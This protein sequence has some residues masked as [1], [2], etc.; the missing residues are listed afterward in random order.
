MSIAINTNDQ[1]LQTN[2]VVAKKR[3]LYISYIKGV[4]IIG[5]TLIH[6]I[7]WSNI[8]LTNTGRIIENLLL[9]CVFLF[10]LTT[11]SVLFIAYGQRQ[12]IDQIKRLFYRGA[13]ILLIYYLYSIVKL[14]L[15]DFSN[16]PIYLQFINKGTFT[17]SDILLFRSF[18]VPITI[19]I[20]YAFLLFISPLIFFVYRKA[21]HPRLVILLLTAGFFVINYFTPIPEINNPVINFLYAR[22]N[23]TFSFMLWTTPLLIGFL[24]ASVGFEKQKRNILLFGAVLALISAWFIIEK[25]QSL[26]L[27]DNEFPLSP[28]FIFCSIFALAI[29]LYFFRII[30]KL[31]S[32]PACAV[33]ATLRLLGDNTLYI[34]IYQ[35]IVIDATRLLFVNND[36]FIWISVPLFFIFYLLFYRKKFIKYYITQTENTLELGA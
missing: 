36:R 32:K 35:W 9:I 13:Q 5:I 28:Y 7:D 3:N 14:L 17:I 34:Y 33:L 11:G 26:W 23:V 25:Q 24:L 19:L 27:A 4:A 8:V 20:T 10:V 6:L 15:F 16:E 21:R 29:L 22:E 31:S 2:Q 18:S 1:S 12:P 30:E